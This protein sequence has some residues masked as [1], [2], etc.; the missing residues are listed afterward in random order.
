MA[1][2]MHV[3]AAIYHLTT[4]RDLLE[5]MQ[6]NWHDSPP[7]FPP[8]FREQNGPKTANDSSDIRDFFNAMNSDESAKDNIKD[9]IFPLF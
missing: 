1:T 4:L 2:G 9:N 5:L 7:S 8:E 3:D 6:L